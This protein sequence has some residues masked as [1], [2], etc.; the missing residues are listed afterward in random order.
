MFLGWQGFWVLSI[1]SRCKK[2]ISSFRQMGWVSPVATSNW[3]DPCVAALVWRGNLVRKDTAH[4]AWTFSSFQEHDYM[5]R[6]RFDSA[7]RDSVNKT[8]INFSFLCTVSLGLSTVLA[9]VRQCN[10]NGVNV[11]GTGIALPGRPLLHVPRS[12][13]TMLTTHVCCLCELTYQDNA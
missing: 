10:P 13:R 2:N 6:T 11:F 3:L 5:T 8:W 1:I 7:T 4:A 9:R 12:G